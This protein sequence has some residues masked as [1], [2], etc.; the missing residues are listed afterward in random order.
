VS[1]LGEDSP[2][3][4]RILPLE[5]IRVAALGR[6]L[7]PRYTSPGRVGWTDPLQSCS[8]PR[9]IRPP[10]RGPAAAQGQD[11]HRLSGRAAVA[12]FIASGVAEPTMGS[13]RP[14][15]PPGIIVTASSPAADCG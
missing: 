5:S 15:V 14:S 12:G 3:S 10:G 8:G 13:Q 9:E 2:L 1:F 6:P 4:M 11:T 7:P